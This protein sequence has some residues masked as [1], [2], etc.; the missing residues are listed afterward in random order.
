MY[1][2]EL[3]L[4]LPVWWV[5]EQS[6][7]W[8]GMGS[9]LDTACFEILPAVIKLLVDYDG[10]WKNDH[11]QTTFSAFL[12]GTFVPVGTESFLFYEGCKKLSGFRHLQFWCLYFWYFEMPSI[13]IFDTGCT[14]WWK[15]ENKTNKQRP[16]IDVPLSYCFFL[17]FLY[18]LGAFLSV[19][20]S[21]RL[22]RV[23][24]RI[25]SIYADV[26]SFPF[27][28]FFFLPFFYTTK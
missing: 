16:R 14:N 26:L 20:S 2:K 28:F 6:D 5:A 22:M 18:E 10:T 4:Y 27:C 12:R 9:L 7:R 23:A 25:A 21:N 13:S 15:W 11:H 3:F 8:I 24:G 19:P 1:S 17:F